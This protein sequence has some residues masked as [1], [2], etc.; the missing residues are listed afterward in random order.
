MLTKKYATVTRLIDAVRVTEENMKAVARWCNGTI[1]E[2]DPK[3]AEQLNQAGHEQV[4]IKINTQNPINEKQTQAR[5]GD[6]V[7]YQNKGY[8]VYTN[9]SF[10]RNFEKVHKDPVPTPGSVHISGKGV[11]VGVD[12]VS[13]HPVEALYYDDETLIKVYDVIESLSVPRAVVIG[14]ISELQ[15]KGILFRE[16]PKPIQMVQVPVTATFEEVAS[17][18]QDAQM[19]DMEKHEREIGA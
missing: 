12:A 14:I 1:H 8:K 19:T 17:A 6:W 10:N 5:V 2:T 4:W 7:L 3:I 16:R 18:I 11:V 13:A 15:T 9:A